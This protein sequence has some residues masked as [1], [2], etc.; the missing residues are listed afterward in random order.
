MGGKD[1]CQEWYLLGMY[2][3]YVNLVNIDPKG[4]VGQDLEVWDPEKIY[5]SCGEQ[6]NYFWKHKLMCVVSYLGYK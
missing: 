2:G 6:I 5:L 3:I 1:Y 4:L